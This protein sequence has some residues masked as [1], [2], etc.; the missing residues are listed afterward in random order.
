M[1]A[2]ALLC[3]PFMFAFETREV[4][5]TGPMIGA[6]AWSV[7]AL[8]IG[9]ISLLFMLIR[10]GAATK[11]TSLLYLTPPTTAVMAWALFGERFPPLAALGM[12]IA[13]C[14]V[15]LVIRK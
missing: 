2:S 7:L 3:L 6:L 13:A 5:W 1:G 8:S 10:H 15:A 9:A 14:G 4:Q 12:V 11:V